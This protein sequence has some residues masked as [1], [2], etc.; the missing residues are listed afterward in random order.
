MSFDVDVARHIGDAEIA[1]AF[2]LNARLTALFGPS[3]AGKT[4]V[5]A[6]IAGLIRPA[7]GHVRV[8]GVTL[9]DAAAGI[10]VPP[11]RRRA[12]YVFQEARRWP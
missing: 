11:H 10:D 8:D 3:G 4:S 2:S 5:L 9:F 7:R 12:G 1:A 6:M